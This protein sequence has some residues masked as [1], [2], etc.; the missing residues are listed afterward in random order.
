MSDETFSTAGDRVFSQEDKTKLTT[1][2]N[3][4]ITVMQEVDDLSLLRLLLKK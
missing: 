4:G 1:L 3:E 2:I